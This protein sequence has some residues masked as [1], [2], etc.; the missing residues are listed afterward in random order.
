MYASGPDCTEHARPESA[1]SSQKGP[2]LMMCRDTSPVTLPR[3]VVSYRKCTETRRERCGADFPGVDV[4]CG[5]AVD[6]RSPHSNNAP[7]ERQSGARG[8]TFRNVI[9]A[10][11]VERVYHETVLVLSRAAWTNFVNLGGDPCPW[12]LE[13]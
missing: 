11:A 5:S 12:N 2:R 1:T 3:S 6:A 4:L 10:K 8:P 13:P 7:V 9:S